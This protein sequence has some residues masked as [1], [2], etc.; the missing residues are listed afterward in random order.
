MAFFVDAVIFRVVSDLKLA[1]FAFGFK[2][3][4]LRGVLD[5][6]LVEGWRVVTLLRRPLRLI[7]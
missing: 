5:S 7:S 6:R 3:S 1:S 4:Q 2:T